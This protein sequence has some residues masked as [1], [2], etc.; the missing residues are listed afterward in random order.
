MFRFLEV[1]DY[2]F[3][4][5]D[6]ILQNLNTSHVF[7]RHG[8]S[9]YI[10]YNVLSILSANK[11]AQSCMVISAILRPQH[12]RIIALERICIIIQ[13]SYQLTDFCKYHF[14]VFSFVCAPLTLPADKCFVQS[15]GA[16]STKFT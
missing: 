2:I 16:G 7:V 3:T 9:F 11:K 6:F 10:Y 5:L 12:Y 15:S 4:I 13:P 1:G 8:N 14:R